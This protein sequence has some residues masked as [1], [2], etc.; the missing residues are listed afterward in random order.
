MKPVVYGLGLLLLIVGAAS[1]VAE[2]LFT[3]AEGGHRS[4]ALGTLWYRLDANSLLGLRAA[5][6]DSLAPALWAPLTYVLSL[7]AWLAFAAPG[8]AVLLLARRE[9]ERSRH[10]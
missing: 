1:G 10:F 6:E 5:I 3:L 2:V 4:L 8:L 7:P 9:R